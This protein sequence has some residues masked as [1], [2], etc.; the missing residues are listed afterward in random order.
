[1]EAHTLEANTKQKS[2]KNSKKV[3][4]Y[5][6]SNKISIKKVLKISSMKGA[7]EIFEK[8]VMYIMVYFS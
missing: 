8:D 6:A 5:Q 2:K 4:K 7:P 3:K 1:M